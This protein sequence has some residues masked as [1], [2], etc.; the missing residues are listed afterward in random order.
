[1]PA[2]AHGA[3]LHPAGDLVA[4]AGADGTRVF[5]LPR[6]LPGVYLGDAE[7]AA[8]AFG[9][10]GE[11]V[12][13][14]PRG[15]VTLHDGRE[16]RPLESIAGWSE[17]RL[18]ATEAGIVATGRADGVVRLERYA[19]DGRRRPW[20]PG[21]DLGDVRRVHAIGPAGAVVENRAGDV[22]R[23]EAGAAAWRRL[24]ARRAAAA[25]LVSDDGRW[26]ALGWA[27]RTEIWTLDGP[28]QVA[29]APAPLV[30]PARFVGKA[31]DLVVSARPGPPER[32]S[33]RERT[34][35]RLA[36]PGTSPELPIFRDDGELWAETLPTGRMRLLAGMRPLADYP[37]M[38]PVAFRPDGQRLVVVAGKQVRLL[39]VGEE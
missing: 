38:R 37:P 33:I 10:G 32:W 30:L 9:I 28:K 36:L 35:L 4:V 34:V 21:L 26:L 39:D 5:K 20:A 18:F 8:L 17:P 14:D 6:D 27:D 13:A 11:V 3:A 7:I 22:A 24:V 23:A 2:V 19:E 12:L 25:V 29:T 31:G 16:P 1:L 15:N